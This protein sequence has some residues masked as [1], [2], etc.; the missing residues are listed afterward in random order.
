MLFT[1]YGYIGFDIVEGKLL[2]GGYVDSN[3][4]FILTPLEDGLRQ[5]R[6]AL[7]FPVLAKLTF[8]PGKFSIQTFVGP[9][10]TVNVGNLEER[11]DEKVTYRIGKDIYGP[12][13]R[14]PPIG[15][16]A[17]ANF[18]VKSGSGTIFLDARYFTDLGYYGLADWFS[19]RRARLSLTAGYEFALNS[20]NSSKY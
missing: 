13:T 7:I 3:G 17:G 9:H 18:G 10:F 2:N 11:K 4:D 15:L 12:K 5:T 14:Q 1:K 19:I 16:T 8:Q 6:H 20:K